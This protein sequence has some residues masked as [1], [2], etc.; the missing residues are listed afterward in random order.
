MLSGKLTLQHVRLISPNKGR[1]KEFVR[2]HHPLVFDILPEMPFW[3]DCIPL[4]AEPAEDV[5][6]NPLRST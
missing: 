6:S 2:G 5:G 3:K 1:G 4:S